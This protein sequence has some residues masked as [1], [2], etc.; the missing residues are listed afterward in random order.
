MKNR[1]NFPPPSFEIWCKVVDLRLRDVSGRPL[2]DAPVTDAELRCW[3]NAGVPARV[4][5]QAL[6]VR[7]PKVRYTLT[8]FYTDRR[9]HEVRAQVLGRLAE[10]GVFQAVGA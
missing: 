6:S 7:V 10:R 1:A 8:R 2:A 3:W 4:V 9:A 5:G